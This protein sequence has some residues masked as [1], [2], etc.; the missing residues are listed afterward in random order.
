MQ[1]HVVPNKDIHATQAAYSLLGA[2]NPPAKNDTC[3]LVDIL[4]V[5]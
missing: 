1:W 5:A 3:V 2:Q 4:H